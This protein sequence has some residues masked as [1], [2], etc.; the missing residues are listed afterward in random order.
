[1]ARVPYGDENS[2]PEVKQLA[3]RIRAPHSTGRSGYGTLTSGLVND[4]RSC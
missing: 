2:S 4:L 1:M 3:E